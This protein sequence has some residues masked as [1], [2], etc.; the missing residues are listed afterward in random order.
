MTRE[1]RGSE[2]TGCSGAPDG[3]TVCVLL[4]GCRLPLCKGPCGP[5]VPLKP[6]CTTA[7]DHDSYYKCANTQT[8]LSEVILS[9][10]IPAHQRKL[11]FH[12]IL[13]LRWKERKHKYF[14]PISPPH[15]PHAHM[16]THTLTHVHTRSHARTHSFGSVTAAWKALVRGTLALRQPGPPGSFLQGCP[17]TPSTTCSE[18]RRAWLRVGSGCPPLRARGE[19]TRAQRH[20]GRGAERTAFILA[21]R[22]TP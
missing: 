1:T 9:V 18:T 4:A 5:Q 22:L 6:L 8:L 15:C 21:A 17:P 13:C 14:M 7:S 2:P 16:C 20:A 19:K 10:K 11:D 3:Q 12:P